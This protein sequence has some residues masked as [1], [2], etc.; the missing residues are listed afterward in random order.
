MR[1]DQWTR[2]SERDFEGMHGGN[3]HF[4][5]RIHRAGLTDLDLEYNIDDSI[6]D[7]DSDQFPTKFRFHS[8]CYPSQSITIARSAPLYRPS[9]KN[10]SKDQCESLRV[11]LDRELFRDKRPHGDS[12]GAPSTLP[13]STRLRRISNGNPCA[14]WSSGRAPAATAAPVNV[15][16]DEA[17]TMSLDP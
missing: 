1:R 7:T 3:L 5:T 4:D 12:K 8:E 2:L 16:G 15:V 17:N 14:V 11:T 13:A 10:K 9:S 6:H